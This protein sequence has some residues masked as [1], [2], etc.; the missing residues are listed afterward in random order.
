MNRP[1]K[2]SPKCNLQVEPV[3]LRNLGQ[4]NNWQYENSKGRHNIPRRMRGVNIPVGM[5]PFSFYLGTKPGLESLPP[6]FNST[7]DP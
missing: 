3:P 4:K 1:V 6:E 7:L 2:R 5:K